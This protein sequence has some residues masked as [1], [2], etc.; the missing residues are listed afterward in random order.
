MSDTDRYTLDQAHLVFA[1]KTNG[2]TWGLLDQI[3]RNDHDDDKMLAS[4]YASYYHWLNVGSSVNWQRAHWL[5]ARVHTV[6]GH[7]EASL[8]HAQRCLAITEEFKED[9]SDFDI[10]YAYEGISRAY[11]FAGKKDTAL[12]YFEL[13]M[14]AAETI[15]DPEDKK[16][17]IGD[18]EG[19]N[20][21][22]LT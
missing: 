7:K 14:K 11:A 9:M 15:E 2:E 20:W 17:V 8:E 21:F 22:G 16:I 6:L 10:F 4:A 18:L 5:L 13:V 19:G 3:D 12:K 1:K